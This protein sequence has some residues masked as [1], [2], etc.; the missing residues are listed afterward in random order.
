[1][2]L[3]EE[4]INLEDKGLLRRLRLV[5]GAQSCRIL[6]EGKSILN[7]CSNNYL[8]LAD[9]ERLK[10]AA[11]EAIA[12]CG[13]GSGASRLV[14][15]NMQLHEKLERKIAEFKRAEKALVFSTGYMANVGIISAL[16]GKNDIVFSDRLNHASIIDGII[17]SRA[18]FKRYPHKDTVA[19]ERMLKESSG[20]EKRLIITDTVFSMDGDIAPLIEIR[21]LAKR[22]GAEIMVDEAHATGVLGETGAGAVEYFELEDQIDIQMGTLSKAVGTFGAYACGSSDLIDYLINKARS[23]IYTTGM[24][25]AICAASIKA[26]QIIQDEPSLRRRLVD[27]AQY[28]RSNLRQLGFDTM[29]SQSAI[30]PVLL[31]DPFLTM[32]FSQRLFDEGIFVQGIR[33]PTVAQNTA[34][35]RVSVM[36]THTKEDLDFAIDKFKKVGKQLCLI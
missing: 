2:S 24:P 5:E 30:I 11:Y 32:E 6:M 18:S 21:Q 7:L 25:A 12:R 8:G 27:N 22:Y 1:M 15:G 28:L 34:R 17:L 20:F 26:L 14:C 33:P 19:L 4:L 23:F 16:V 29:D 31:K 9:D 35:L 10:D 36:A 13:L 3:K